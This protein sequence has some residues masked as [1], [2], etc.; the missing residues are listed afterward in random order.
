MNGRTSYFF[1]EDLSRIHLIFPNRKRFFELFLSYFSVNITEKS[2]RLHTS[3]VL[4]NVSVFVSHLCCLNKIRS[5]SSWKMR[6][7]S[8]TRVATLVEHVHPVCLLIIL[9]DD[10]VLRN[11][12]AGS[13]EMVFIKHCQVLGDLFLIALSN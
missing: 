3:V 11:V 10:D 1:P 8:V 4:S 9:L 2:A 5:G 6:F 12:F 13:L 7:A